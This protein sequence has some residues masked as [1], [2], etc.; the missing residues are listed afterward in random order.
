VRLLLTLFLL[1]PVAGKAAN[2]LQGTW[3]SDHDATMRFVR[4][5]A[6]LETNQSEFLEGSLGQLKLSFDTAK[7]RYRTITRVV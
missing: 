7:L 5:H 3:Q 1:L 4:D 2:S 6:V